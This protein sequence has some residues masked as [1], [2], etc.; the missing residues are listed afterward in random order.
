MH[1]DLNGF[2]YFVH[3]QCC[4]WAIPLPLRR[5]AMLQW[6]HKWLKH[7][8]TYLSTFLVGDDGKH[9]FFCGSHTAS[10]KASK[11]PWWEYGNEYECQHIKEL[12]AKGN[13]WDGFFLQNHVRAQDDFSSS[14]WKP[15]FSCAWVKVFL[16]VLWMQDLFPETWESGNTLGGWRSCSEVTFPSKEYT[17]YK[18]LQYNKTR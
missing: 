18:I 2:M 15:L 5:A 1:K 8:S 6:A 11:I 13:W 14:M 12:C 17:L 9:E 16:E 10:R 3:G 7:H 4:C